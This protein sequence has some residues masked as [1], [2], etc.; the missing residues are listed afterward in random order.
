MTKLFLYIILI[1]TISTTSLSQVSYPDF[2]DT[3]G[4][5]I[6]NDALV[7][8]NKLRLTKALKNE[9]GACW[10]R[11]QQIVV[12]TFETTFRFQITDCGG[13]DGG[14]DGL[15]FVIQNASDSAIGNH[16]GGIAYYG[17]VNSLAIEFDMYDNGRDPN[18]NHIS[19]QSRGTL[20][21]SYDH[22]YSL[23]STTALPNMSNGSIYTVKINYINGLLAVYLN[24]LSLPLF[25]VHVLIDTLLNLNGERAWIGF[26]AATGNGYQNHDILSWSFANEIDTSF[27]GTTPVVIVPG[28]MGSPLYNNTS[29]LDHL[30]GGERIW[31]DITKM[32][33]PDN[34]LEALALKENGIDPQNSGD[35][36]VKSPLPNDNGRTIIDELNWRPLKPF[37][38]FINYL[39]SSDYTLDNYNDDHQAQE[40]LFFYT[41]D[42]RKSLWANGD[43]LSCF[44]DSVLKWTGASQV[45]I[46]A[47]S[48][49]GLVSKQYIQEF[50][51][52]RIHK[53]VFVGTPHL[54]APK[55]EYTMFTGDI[56][57]PW[58]ADICNNLA[59]IKYIS[60]NWPAPYSLIP[61]ADYFYTG[62]DNGISLGA[63]LY[64][65]CLAYYNGVNYRY[66]DYEATK[67]FLKNTAWPLTEPEFNSSLINNAYTNHN[68]LQNVNFDNIEVYNI[69]GTGLKTLSQVRFT[70]AVKLKDRATHLSTLTG[71][72]TVPLRSAEIVNH[73]LTRANYYVSGTEHMDLFKDD[74]VQ[75]LVLKILQDPPDTLGFTTALITS[76]PPAHYS[77]DGILCQVSSPVELHVYD[78]FNNHTGP[79]GDT[80]WENVIPESFYQGGPLSNPHSAKYISVPNA[81]GYKVVI[82]SLDTA[83][84]FDFQIEQVSQGQ[85]TGLLLFDSI[86]TEPNFSAIMEMSSVTPDLFFLLDNDGDSVYESKAWPTRAY[87]NQTVSSGWNLLSLPIA[88]SDSNSAVIY[89]NAESRPYIYNSGYQPRDNLTTGIGY[90]VKFDSPQTIELFG[91][92]KYSNTIEVRAGW[93]II[94]SLTAAVPV[95]AITSEPENIISSSFYS[96]NDVYFI[97]DSLKPGLGYWV[98]IN[99]AGSIIL[100]A[101]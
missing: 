2:S 73:S 80:T 48:M 30:D 7:T 42:W 9:K 16:G 100:H 27:M 78:K 11:N 57:L 79:T 4:L 43:S 84:Y 13:L 94:G 12:D 51:S 90:W 86:P 19:V 64:N 8:T 83:A 32:I 81:D 61:S 52:S 71:D 68:Q 18:N 93:N 37:R 56:I 65:Y 40:N 97:A 66:L 88:T 99:Q 21:N 45:N 24:N 92:T 101:E 82:K 59:T 72:G 36:I 60:R 35:N 49:G 10:H 41:Y 15:A 20:S 96:Y 38:S 23:G 31:V 33:G 28:I 26:T 39:E 85:V 46:V 50:G 54:G 14:A 58:L 29:D 70:G 17:I 34:F 22:I 75:N 62:L 77:A 74:G 53:I 55:L 89:P 44:I 25:T 6:I 3:T 67:V 63:G 47:H 95:S 91:S 98:K 5:K 1:F 87:L 69:V 76:T